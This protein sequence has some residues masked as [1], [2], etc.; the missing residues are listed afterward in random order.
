[1]PKVDLVELVSPAISGVT[2]VPIG[3]AREREQEAVQQGA[4]RALNRRDRT[5]ARG[6]VGSCV[7]D[8]EVRRWR[9]RGDPRRV[10][11]SRK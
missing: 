5:G 1:L 7:R 9:R 8:R 3:D 2:E 11:L 6:V 4:L 10:G